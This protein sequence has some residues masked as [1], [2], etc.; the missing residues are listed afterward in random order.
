MMSTRGREVILSNRTARA[1]SVT[2]A[3]IAS[4]VSLSAVAANPGMTGSEQPS[5]SLDKAQATLKVFGTDDRQV[6]HNT[7]DFP[8]S[9][10]GIVQATWKILDKQKLVSSGTGTLVG[11]NLVLTSGHT[12][13][14]QEEGW[15]DEAVFIPGVNGGVE[16]FGRAHSIRMISQRGWVEYDDHRFD[17]ALIVLDHSIGEKT[18]YMNVSAQP[19]SFFVNRLL[20]T[21]GY[22]AETKPG[23]V[24]Y[25]TSGNSLDVQDGLIRDLL[26]S[27]P[28]QS[29]SP[30]WFYQAD[31]VERYV[32]GV[33]TGSR[34]STANGQTISD[35]NVAVKID[36]AFAKWIHETRAKYDP[37][38]ITDT[39][40]RV[41]VTGAP[42]CGS[43]ISGFGLMMLGL[44]AAR[45]MTGRRFSL[46]K[47]H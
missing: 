44:M 41:G 24:L 43:G 37:S 21:A 26:D 40:S 16:P 19:D 7:T 29:G 23:N 25:F 22:P 27:E 30:L 39:S 47:G 3:L 34:Q 8:W 1:R 20:N 28:G 9:A 11:N 33:L 42:M 10:I 31:P 18:G 12:I 17:L 14:D 6:V 13:Y 35:Y 5:T 32:V 4:L 38:L 36:D 15:A 2:I 45:A 46:N